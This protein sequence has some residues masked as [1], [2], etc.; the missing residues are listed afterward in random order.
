MIPRLFFVMMTLVT[1][2]ALSAET[3]DFASRLEKLNAEIK[4]KPDEPM[5]LYCKAQCLMSL[6]KYDDGYECAK[7]AMALFIKKNDKLSWM[8]LESIELETV[9]IDV[10]FNMG[11]KERTPPDIGIV[12]PLSFRVWSKD[13]EKKLLETYDFEI[14]YVNGKP[15]TAAIGQL[16]GEVHVNFGTMEPDVKYSEIRKKAETLIKERLKKQ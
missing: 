6:G 1:I 16:Q 13:K 12:R 14:G 8:L 7:Q 10:H 9:R 5:L 15:S 2:S 3:T 11:P 4:E